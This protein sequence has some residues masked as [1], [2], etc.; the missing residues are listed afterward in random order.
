MLLALRCRWQQ[1]FNS[2][3]Q[4][5]AVWTRAPQMQQP[6]ILHPKSCAA[7]GGSPP[8]EAGQRSRKAVGA[9]G[10]YCTL[11]I[12]TQ[13]AGWQVW[14]SPIALCEL[15]RLALCGFVCPMLIQHGEAGRRRTGEAAL[16]GTRGAAAHAA[17]ASQLRAAISNNIH[18]GASKHL[19]RQAAAS[20][21][22]AHAMPTPEFMRAYRRRQRAL[23]GGTGREDKGDCTDAPGSRQEPQEP[24]H[25]TSKPPAPAALLLLPQRAVPQLC[26]DWTLSHPQRAVPTLWSRSSWWQRG[27]SWTVRGQGRPVLGGATAS[28]A[29]SRSQRPLFTNPDRRCEPHQGSRPTC[30]APSALPPLY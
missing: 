9:E 10:T 11:R 17:L 2:F 25:T 22:D 8:R 15:S 6:A 20:Q 21:N 14:S 30:T 28:D 24:W 18:H 26:P 1:P 12:P 27:Q 29:G 23:K 5:T 19:R 13:E 3:P 16:L 4:C 7:R